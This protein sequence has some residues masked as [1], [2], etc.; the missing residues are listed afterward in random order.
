MA[1]ATPVIILPGSGCTPTRECNFYAWFHD[2][3]KTKGYEPRMRNMPD[4]HVCR[5][6]IWLPFIN[7]ELGCDESCVL[8]GHS[9]GAIAAMRVAERRK[10]KGIILV[11]AY[12]DDLG[13]EGERASGK[14]PCQI[15]CPCEKTISDKDF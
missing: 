11:A 1:A 10:V 14:G 13:D 2:K 8:V 12:D 7:K 6:K 5:Q 3:I 15:S 4:P 9:S